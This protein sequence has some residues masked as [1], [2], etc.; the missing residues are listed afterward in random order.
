MTRAGLRPARRA[1]PVGSLAF[2]L[3]PPGDNKLIYQ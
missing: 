1:R 2:Y 3:E